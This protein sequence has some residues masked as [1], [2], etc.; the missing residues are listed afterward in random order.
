VD[1]ETGDL[2]RL[3]DILADMLDEALFR[4]QHGNMWAPEQRHLV[5]EAL[6][7]WHNVAD[8]FLDDE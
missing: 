3:T 8:D 1:S 5:R 6:D 4:M 7:A 2:A